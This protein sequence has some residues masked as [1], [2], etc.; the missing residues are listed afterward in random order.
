LFDDSADGSHWGVCGV[1]EEVKRMSNYRMVVKN[2][3]YLFQ[4]VR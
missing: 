4:K 1:I 3:N 2:P